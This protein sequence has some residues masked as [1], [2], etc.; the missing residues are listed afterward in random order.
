MDC[1]GIAAGDYRL[2]L[3]PHRGGSIVAFSWRGQDLLR[4]AAGDGVLDSSCFPLVPFSNRIAGSRFVFEGR[5]VRLEPNHP[6]AVGEP[7]LHGFGWLADWSVAE[8]SPDRAVL[9]HENA[10]GAWPWPYRATAGFVLD[11]GGLLTSLEL[12]NLSADPMPAGLGFHPYFPRTG[13]TLYRGLHRGEWQ[14]GPDCLPRNLDHRDEARDWWNGRPVETRE[15]DTVYTG[16]DGLL[17]IEWPERALRTII[18]PCGDLAFTTVY[19]PAGEDFFCVE[20]VSHATDVFNEP[21]PEN[22]MRVLQRG[23][24]WSVSMRIRAEATG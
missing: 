19:V 6:A 3:A 21:V 14:V 4:P 5:E 2:E 9:V 17:E 12:E 11:E 10:G 20:P 18:D 1:I 13:H 22:G 7:V 8:L 24:R 23:E 15:V 16:R